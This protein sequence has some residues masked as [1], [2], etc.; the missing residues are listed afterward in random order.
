MK[1]SIVSSGSKLDLSLNQ[2]KSDL[3]QLCSD[4]A[5]G[6]FTEATRLNV[7]FPTTPPLGLSKVQMMPR[8]IVCREFCKAWLV[9]SAAASIVWYP[10]MLGR[11][12]TGA[13]ASW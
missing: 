8:G 12:K 1:R 2:Q 10:A 11:D 4:Q 13:D 9:A 6:E 7:Y 3:E 5:S